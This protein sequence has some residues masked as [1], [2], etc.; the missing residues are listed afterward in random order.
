MGVIGFGEI[1][2]TGE[3]RVPMIEMFHVSKVL[4]SQLLRQ[5]SIEVSVYIDSII[6]LSNFGEIYLGLVNFE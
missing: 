3:E 5:G 6:E 1:E 2:R 4:F